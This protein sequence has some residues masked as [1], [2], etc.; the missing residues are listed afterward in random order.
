MQRKQSKNSKRNISKIQKISEDKKEKKEHLREGN[1]QNSLWQ[2]SY[3]V[4]Q[5]KNTMRNTG[6]GWKKIGDNR[7]K[8]EQE[9]KEQWKL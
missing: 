7:K 9:N 5:T 4:G 2:E 8:E 6:Q 1:Y 3:L